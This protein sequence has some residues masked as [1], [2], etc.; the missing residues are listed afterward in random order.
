MFHLMYAIVRGSRLSYLFSPRRRNTRNEN[1]LRQTSFNNCPQS[2]SFSAQGSGC[3]FFLLLTD[4]HL[5]SP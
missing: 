1:H 3:K 5:K 2:M 4:T